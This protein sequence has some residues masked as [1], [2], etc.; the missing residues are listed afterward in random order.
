MSKP[1]PSTNHSKND[2]TSTNHTHNTLTDQQHTPPPPPVLG[3]TT[4]DVRE[5]DGGGAVKM[6][7]GGDQGGLVGEAERVALEVK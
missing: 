7:T 2:P 1:S 6:S 5:G 4:Q 3:A